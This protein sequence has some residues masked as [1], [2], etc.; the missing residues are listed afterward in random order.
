M[1]QGSLRARWRMARHAPPDADGA[2]RWR[3]PFCAGFLCS[4]DFP[5]TIRRPSTVPLVPATGTRA[6][7]CQGIQTVSAAETALWQ[8]IPYGTTV[9]RI[10][11]GRR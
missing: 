4:R 11:M 1:S 9:W 10:S 7:C 5:R 3:C 6:Q 2:T 8:R